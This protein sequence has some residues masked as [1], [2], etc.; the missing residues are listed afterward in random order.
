M[1]KPRYEMERAEHEARQIA[2]LAQGYTSIARAAQVVSDP[3]TPDGIKQYALG[4]LN[5]LLIKQGKLN[6]QLGIIQE[7]IDRKI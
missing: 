6:D 2:Y 5:K 3:R 4:E 7:N 1:A